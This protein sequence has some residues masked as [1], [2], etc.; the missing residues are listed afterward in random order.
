MASQQAYEIPNES[1][2]QVKRRKARAGA[3][4][5]SRGRTSNQ[6]PTL[7]RVSELDEDS[8]HATYAGRDLPPH[9][10]SATG[11]RM[12][13]F[14][15]VRGS[16]GEQK[17]ETTRHTLNITIIER[18]GE[19]AR[20]ETGPRP[21]REVMATLLTM[22]ME[23]IQVRQEID[24]TKDGEDQFR[25]GVEGLLHGIEGEGTGRGHR[26]IHRRRTRD[27]GAEFQAAATSAQTIVFLILHRELRTGCWYN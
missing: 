27:R 17:E 14:L 12:S 4:T 23:T 6:R 24:G 26:Q 15:K 19:G 16:T 10:D 20:L 22:T 11:I 3:H 18:K 1:I 8:F 2:S 13:L 5:L 25:P 9:M 7:E 21:E